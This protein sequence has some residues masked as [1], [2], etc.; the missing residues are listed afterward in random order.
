M[1]IKRVHIK[2]FR[3]LADVPVDFDA[4]TAFV[5][6][7]GSGKS[8]VLRAIGA[9]Y[10]STLSVSTDDFYNRD[11]SRSI[12]IAITFADLGDEEKDLFSPYIDHDSLTVTKVIT[13]SG[14]RYH[15]TRVQHP[16]FSDVRKISG[17]ADRKKAYDELR[18]KQQYHDLPS[19]TSAGKADDQLRAW[20]DAHTDQC[21]MMRDD[22]QFFGFRQVG[23]SRLERF[24]RYVFVPAVRDAGQDATDSRG[25]AIYDLMELVVR[26]VLAQNEAFAEFRKRTQ[27]EY[28]TLI[29]PETIPQ[30]GQLG[31]R[32]TQVLRQYVPS[33]AVILQ[34]LE[35]GELTIPPPKTAVRLQEDG[36]TAPVDRVGHGLQ[37]AFILS[38]LQGLAAAS[39]TEAS[40][41]ENENDE[42][43]D[44]D[45]ETMRIPDLILAIEEPELYQHPNRQRHLARILWDLSQ[46]TIMGVA[47]RT[48]V[49]YCTHSPLFVD[50]TRFD[51]VRRLSKEVC[52]EQEDL[53]LV[54]RIASRPLRCLASDLQAAQDGE[55]QR[56]FTAESVKARMVTLM[57][58]WMNEGFFAD[59]V[60]LV[61]GEDDRAA[62]LGAA[63]FMSPDLEALGVA[64]IPC[65]GKD[66]IDRPYLVFSGLD[67]PVYVVFDGDYGCKP[68]TN[69]RLQRLLG[70]PNDDEKDAPPDQINDKYAIFEGDLDGTIRSAVGEDVYGSVAQRFMQD[71]GYP[72][73]DRCK[74]SPVFIQAVLQQAQQKRKPVQDLEAIVRCIC[75]LLPKNRRVQEASEQNDDG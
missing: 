30:L 65:G 31:E 9:F 33:A 3:C 46:G 42:P 6:P 17:K 44:A 38:L 64:V 18:Q 26:S 71:Y 34:W 47:K 52:D 48:Q 39:A 53:P 67:L 27:E 72:D 36:F 40:R 20:E 2:N 41:A 62:I 68:A 25:S 45:D 7:N 69:R 1:R 22:G 11:E 59:V 10:E 70:V 32:L 13:S 73:W 21:E 12:E 43:G 5:G 4:L 56:T 74:K 8:A 37:R 24:T 63:L 66:S 29:S 28:S 16:G 15:G 57:T 14:F 55:S 51:S 61:E 49:I 23:Q 19:A 35:A 54:T 50:L 75:D 58:P 60:V